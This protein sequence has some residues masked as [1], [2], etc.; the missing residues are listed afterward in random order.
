MTNKHAFWDMSRHQYAAAVN[1]ELE[2]YGK[3]KGL[4][5]KS[6][7]A[8]KFVLW[9]E[10]TS[11]PDA[12]PRPV[13]YK[14]SFYDRVPENE[15]N[16]YVPFQ[17]K[18]ETLYRKKETI[19]DPRTGQPKEDFVRLSTAYSAFQ[20]L[21]NNV[22]SL[23]GNPKYATDLDTTTMPFEHPAMQA[24]FAVAL[25]LE[26]N[27]S[28]GKSIGRKL[29]KDVNPESL[30]GTEFQYIRHHMGGPTADKFITA[31]LKDPKAPLATVMNPAAMHRNRD[32]T[33]AS[34]PA[35]FK[36]WTLEDY[37]KWIKEGKYVEHMPNVAKAEA[38]RVPPGLP[39]PALQEALA[40]TPAATTKP[41]SNPLT[42]NPTSDPIAAL[43]ASLNTTALPE[44]AATSAAEAKTLTTLSADTESQALLAGSVCFQKQLGGIPLALM[45]N[46]SATNAKG[47]RLMLP[48]EANFSQMLDSCLV[49]SIQRSLHISGET[50]T[51]EE[52]KILA[53][54]VKIKQNNTPVPTR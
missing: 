25:A 8:L 9:I 21:D 5:D 13:E 20:L 36:K 2:R 35:D 3:E 11:S 38:L 6:I 44:P 29:G 32:I 34:N 16:L 4:S 37:A 43:L 7:T 39:L 31:Y 24:R 27:I 33:L 14:Q 52:L 10:S 12:K 45:L 26:D 51:P 47:E 49:N 48:T 19:T 28:L 46:S 50:V 1:T 54:Q 17:K 41:G 40:I 30:M 23:K 22:N 42:I 18:G 53:E 15:R